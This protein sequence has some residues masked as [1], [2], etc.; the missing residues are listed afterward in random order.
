[1]LCQKALLD[2]TQDVR[3]ALL[4]HSDL[5]HR[6]ASGIHL[7]A[8]LSALLPPPPKQGRACV[9]PSSVSWQSHTP[10]SSGYLHVLRCE[11]DSRLMSLN[12]V[13]LFQRS[14]SDFLDVPLKGK[15]LEGSPPTALSQSRL[16]KTLT[17]EQSF[18]SKKSTHYC[19]QESSFSTL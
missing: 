3:L 8:P 12:Y 10:V 1:M 6:E 7:L 14:P 15:G 11:L 13:N 18:P 16:G 17:E 19:C 4:Y 2:E 9:S 5:V